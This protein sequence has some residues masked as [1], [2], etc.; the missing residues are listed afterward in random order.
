MFYCRFYEL[1]HYTD[2]LGLSTISLSDAAIR[3]YGAE[4]LMNTYVYYMN[5]MED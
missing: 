1:F 4:K 5:R 3:K 2:K